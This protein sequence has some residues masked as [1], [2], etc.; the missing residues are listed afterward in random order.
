MAAFN[1]PA[2]CACLTE[3]GTLVLGKGGPYPL[4]QWT[5][6]NV[7]ALAI[8]V[9]QLL[10]HCRVEWSLHGAVLCAFVVLGALMCGNLEQTA[11][12]DETVCRE[13]QHLYNSI[14]IS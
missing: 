3:L 1:V 12:M 7:G 4:R 9:H 11:Q 2:S 13:S 6:Q 8:T 5:L 14:G 10:E